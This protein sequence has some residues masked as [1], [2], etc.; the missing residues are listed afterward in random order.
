MKNRPRH[1]R[2]GYW[3]VSGKNWGWLVRKVEQWVQNIPAGRDEEA[4]WRHNQGITGQEHGRGGEEGDVQPNWSGPSSFHK[5]GAQR[6]FYSPHPDAWLDE[7]IPGLE[8]PYPWERFDQN[9]GSNDA[10]WND[11]G[12]KDFEDDPQRRRQPVNPERRQKHWSSYHQNIKDSNNTGKGWEELSSLYDETEMTDPS[13]LKIHSR[14][15]KTSL[16]TGKRKRKK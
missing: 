5:K 9:T 10:N 11:P 15:K 4:S 16:R 2:I 6:E 14:S 12:R 7:P 8:A 3:G 1:R 13:Q